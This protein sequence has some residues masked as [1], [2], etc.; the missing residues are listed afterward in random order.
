MIYEAARSTLKAMQRDK[1]HPSLKSLQAEHQWLFDEQ[2][3]LYDE[4]AKLKK[5]AKQIDTIKT[6]VDIF[7]S[8]DRDD[9]KEKQRDNQ[10]S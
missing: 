1:K 10:L 3:R 8:L 4:H 2:Q 6:N 7:L 9:E 5:Q